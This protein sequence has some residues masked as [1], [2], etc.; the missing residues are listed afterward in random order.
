VG[1]GRPELSYGHEHG[2]RAIGATVDLTDEERATREALRDEYDRLEAEYAEADELPDEIDARLG[3]I[4]QA[5]DAFEQRPAIYDPADIAIAGVFVSLD[6]DGSLSVDRGYVR[7][8]DERPVDPKA[9]I[10]RRDGDTGQPATP[11]VQR[12]VITVGGQA[13]EPEDDEED[14]IKPLPE[15]LVIELT[16]R[17]LALRNAVAEHPARRHDHAAAQAGQRHLPAP[18][19]RAASRPASATSSSPPNRRS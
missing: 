7:P 14:G 19:P 9:T 6:A 18:A 17:T 8:E 1:R 12:A 10:R 15:R 5:L 16:A 13:A 11:A 3:E 2:L 4:E